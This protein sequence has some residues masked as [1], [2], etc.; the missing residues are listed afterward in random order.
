MGW[1]PKDAEKSTPPLGR[2]KSHH[3]GME[4]HR[5]PAAGPGWPALNRTI[6]GWKLYFN[7]LGVF[8]AHGFK[9]HHSGME[10]WAAFNAIMTVS[11]FKSHHSGMETVVV[12]TPTA[13]DGKL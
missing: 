8:C 10:T 2:F 6:V 4:T 5:F 9:S 1:K 3:S 13:R 11:T 7:G 12:G